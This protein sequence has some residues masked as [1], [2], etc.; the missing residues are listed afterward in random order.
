MKVRDIA[1]AR[2]DADPA[3]TVLTLMAEDGGRISG[4]FHNQSEDDLRLALRRPWIGVG[5]DGTALNLEADGAPHPRNYGTH[6]RVLAHYARDLK[7]LTFE[8]AVRKMTSLPAQIL[9]LHDR[10]LLRP[11]YAADVVIF[12]PAKVSDTATFEKPKSYPAGIPSVLVNGV[13]VINNGQHTGAKP[14]KPLLGPGTGK[15]KS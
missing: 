1:R 3:D 11:G 9:G 12:D 2:G 5:S 4:V 15:S 7:I 8:D 10:G 13:V 14:G 6:A